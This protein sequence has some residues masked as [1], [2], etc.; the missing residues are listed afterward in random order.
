MG[1]SSLMAGYELPKLAIRVQIPAGA[2]EIFLISFLKTLNQLESQSI[3]L[4]IS[5]TILLIC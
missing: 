3:N 4:N 2:F 1:T 5:K